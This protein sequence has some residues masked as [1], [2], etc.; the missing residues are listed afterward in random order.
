MTLATALFLGGVV[1]IMLA[2]VVW[3]F[4]DLAVSAAGAVTCVVLA[5][6]GIGCWLASAAVDNHQRDAR[7]HAA[8]K[9]VDAACYPKVVTNRAEHDGKIVFDCADDGRLRS[10][11]I[12]D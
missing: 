7:D 9:V 1:A 11:R 2:L 8:Q 5:M 10:V 12:K 4:A 6:I 3:L